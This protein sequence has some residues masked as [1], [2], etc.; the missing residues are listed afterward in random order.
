MATRLCI[1][2]LLMTGVFAIPGNAQNVTGDGVVLIDQQHALV[3]GIGDGDASGFPVTITQPGI[4]RLTSNL[5]VPTG[6]NGI[7][8]ASND[9]TLDL[10]GFSIRGTFQLPITTEDVG[11]KYVAFK[12]SERSRGTGITIR[13][14][15]IYNFMF[16]IDLGENSRLCSL[17]D[18]ILSVGLDPSISVG[19]V[20]GS[21]TRIWH[22]T[23]D[24]IIFTVG[25]PS[26][27]A[28]TIA[29][30]INRVNNTGNCAFANNATVAIGPN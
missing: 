5:Q 19:L 24:D 20:F 22:V 27:V 21:F 15:A 30:N 2:A 26:V 13:N 29:L 25:C 23:A 1:S 12:F 10:N 14:G 7:E 6:K 9:V 8:I 17:E 18:L 4:Y 3:G 28:E 16:P 11:V